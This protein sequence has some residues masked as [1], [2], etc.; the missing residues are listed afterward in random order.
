MVGVGALPAQCAVLTGLSA[1]VE[2]LAVEASLTGNRRLVYQAIYNDPLTAAVLS[3]AEIR[4]MV[5]ELFACNEE[6]LPQFR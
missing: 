4:N 6:H 2:E 3:L 1:Q 5:D